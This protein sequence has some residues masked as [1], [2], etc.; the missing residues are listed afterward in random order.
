MGRV[1][2]VLQ[3]RGLADNTIIVFAGDN[4]LALG[5][6]GLMGKQNLYDH[7]VRVP[8]VMAGPSI[9]A[10]QRHNAYCY[11]QD[12][13]PTLCDLIGIPIPDTVEGKSLV[14]ALGNPADHVRDIILCA[15]RGLQRSARDRR[16][17]LI[18][19]VVDGQ[20]TTQLFDL[21]SDPWELTNLAGDPGHSGQIARLR[22]E[23]T[24]WRTDLDDDQPEQGQQFWPASGL[25]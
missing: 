25:I 4:G 22:R 5:Q 24:R 16:Y 1:L 10:D 14:P 17:K 7:S 3:A 23:L 11:L 19:Y 8:L 2:E 15:Y 12:I 18:E 13:Y 21:E 20:R 6:H 9:P